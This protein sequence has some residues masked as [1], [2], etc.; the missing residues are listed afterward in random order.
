MSYG[1]I[2]RVPAP[3]EMYDAS[4]A[5]VMRRAGD[6]AETGLI[7]HVARATDTGFEVMEVWQSRE[8]CEA[9]NRDVVAPAL[10]SLG[11]PA[12]GPPPETVEF[13][14][15]AVVTVQSFEEAMSGAAGR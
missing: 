4:H 11:I 1:V 15:R 12:D 10:A 9:F 6:S 3:V 7:L 5:E 2:V 14:P 13:D 8:H